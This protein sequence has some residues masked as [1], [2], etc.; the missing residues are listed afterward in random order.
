MAHRPRPTVVPCP[1]L[2]AQAYQILRRGGLKEDHIITMMFD[3]VARHPL[4]P[5]PNK[6]YNQPG[7]PDVYEGVKVVRVCWEICVCA[8]LNDACTGFALVLE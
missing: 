5:F 2:L 8:G 3:D 4:N 7:G 1:P 6:L